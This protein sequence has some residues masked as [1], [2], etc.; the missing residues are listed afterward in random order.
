MLEG[1]TNA[2]FSNDLTTRKLT[3]SYLFILGNSPILFK[4]SL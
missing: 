4:S 1:Y 3:Y 2:S